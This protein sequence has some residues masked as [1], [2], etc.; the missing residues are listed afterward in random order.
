[1]FTIRPRA[2]AT[3]ER[4]ANWLDTNALRTPAVIIASHRQRGCSQNGSAHVKRP[5]STMRSYPPHTLLTNTSSRPHSASI[6]AK[7]CATSSSLVWSQ[8]IRT[9]LDGSEA[10]AIVRPLAKTSVPESA[11]AAAMPRP[12]PRLAP[13]TSATEGCWSGIALRGRESCAERSSIGPRRGVVKF[14]APGLCRLA[15]DTQPENLH[16]SRSPH[17]LST[18][19]ETDRKSTRLNSSH[20]SISY[21]V[22]CLKKKIV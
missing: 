14:P 20:P 17:P 2:C 1:M 12:T 13:V 19:G 21:A 6:L 9:T 10:W 18:L 16:S 22:F 5:S 8:L 7:S 4:D 3:I 11:S 15:T